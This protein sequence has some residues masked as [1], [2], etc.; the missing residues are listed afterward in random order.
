MVQPDKSLGTESEF[1]FGGLGILDGQIPG[2]HEMIRRMPKGIDVAKHKAA[3]LHVG[4]VRGG[5]P[6]LS[7]QILGDL[8]PQRSGSRQFE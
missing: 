1:A 6:Q 2:Q 5:L 8:H 3:H 4:V 7:E